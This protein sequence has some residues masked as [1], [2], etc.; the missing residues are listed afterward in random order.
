MGQSFV[1]R[2]LEWSGPF[3]CV[4]AGE[5]RRSEAIT[6]CKWDSGLGSWDKK[7]GPDSERGSKR[8][9]GSL[10]VPASAHVPN[11]RVAFLW[12]STLICNGCSRSGVEKVEIHRVGRST[13]MQ[14]LLTCCLVS[15]DGAEIS[16]YRGA[17]INRLISA[18]GSCRGLWLGH[19]PSLA[20]SQL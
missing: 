7:Q 1:F 10:Q 18:L 14:V 20:R 3:L 13:Y 19:D 12:H 9:L 17:S 4:G 5:T 11:R 16:H 15:Q 8:L 2:G 6:G